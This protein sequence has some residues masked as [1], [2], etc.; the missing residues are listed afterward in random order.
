MLKLL[1]LG[2]SAA[3]FLVLRS[4]VVSFFI[5]RSLRQ[6]QKYIAL[7]W[8]LFGLMEQY[9]PSSSLSFSPS[10]EL[11]IFACMWGVVRLKDRA[12]I[13]MYIRGLALQIWCQ[14]L[15]D[16]GMLEIEGIPNFQF[17]LAPITLQAPDYVNASFSAEIP[18]EET[19]IESIENL[20]PNASYIGL[21]RVDRSVSVFYHV[22]CQFCSWLDWFRAWF[23]GYFF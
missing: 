2:I 15:V 7:F 16:H 4:R 22:S 18:P 23:S 12:R 6:E 11:W 20:P 14:L 1:D 3:S 13:L 8:L 17:F 9:L 21:V 5:C 19:K 10:Q